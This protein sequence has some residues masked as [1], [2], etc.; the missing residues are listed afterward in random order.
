[1]DLN[2]TFSPPEKK[3]NGDDRTTLN[4][5][6]IP[7]YHK[8][9]TG[10]IVY[11]VIFIVSIPYLL[12]KNQYLG[13]LEGY[14]PNVDMIATVLGYQSTEG[15]FKKFSKYFEYLYNPATKTSYGYWS[16]TFINYMALLGLTYYVSYYTLKSKSLSKGW[17]RAFIMLLITYLLPG[18]YI[19]YY[20][21]K[22]HYY[23]DRFSMDNN[24]KHIFVY[25]FGFLIILFFIFSEQFLIDLFGDTIAK[26]LRKVLKIS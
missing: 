9:L 22:L 24:L 8:E 7:D 23:L 5:P 20:M 2:I 15:D 19:A 25:G 16:Q 10:F 3:Y 4:D 12:I 13:I 21:Q 1:M 26:T 6:P 11:F 17:G 14:I 18:N